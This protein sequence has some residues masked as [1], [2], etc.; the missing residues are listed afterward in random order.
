MSQIVRTQFTITV[1]VLLL[2]GPYALA[3]NGRRVPHPNPLT[4]QK[5]RDGLN[6][7]LAL[8]EPVQTTLPV[9]LRLLEDQANYQGKPMS[10]ALDRSSLGQVEIEDVDNLPV[11]LFRSEDPIALKVAL[12]DIVSQFGLTYAIAE[13]RVLVGPRTAIIERVYNQA[14][15]LNVEEVPLRKV[16]RQLA[17]QTGVNLVLD[18]R[19]KEELKTTMAVRDMSLKTTVRLLAEMSDLQA[20]PLR[21]D[22][23]F[24]TN[25]ENAAR[26]R[27]EKQ[28][29]AVPCPAPDPIVSFTSALA[30]PAVAALRG[31]G[32]G[33]LLYFPLR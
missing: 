5:L 6:S 15:N 23:F 32:P 7:K 19:I 16:L 27:M 3:Q 33:G 11:R 31:R 21:E 22:G 1:V 2:S 14:V 13:G 17:D 20:V 29:W 28:E 24:L 8:T 9:V 25:K 12:R 4:A 26:L 30:G 10:I 18:S